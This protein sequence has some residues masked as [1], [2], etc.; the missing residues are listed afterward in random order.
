MRPH[1]DRLASQVLENQPNLPR[2]RFR[3]TGLPSSFKVPVVSFL[4]LTCGYALPHVVTIA[5]GLDSRLLS[6]L[7]HLYY[8]YKPRE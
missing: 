2:I 4:P 3:E 7:V 1:Q 6:T 8:G 5:E